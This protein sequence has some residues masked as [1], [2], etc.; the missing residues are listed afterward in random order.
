[1]ALSFTA[2][3]QPIVQ[4]S[5]LLSSNAQKGSASLAA[6][7]SVS[8][9]LRQ[10]SFLPAHPFSKPLASGSHLASSGKVAI[11]SPRAKVSVGDAAPSFTLKD[12][13]GR[14]FSLSKFKG[15]NVVLYFYP[16]DDTPGCTKEACAFRDSYTVFR[17]LGAEV[18]GISADSPESH[19]LI[20]NNQFQPEKHVEKALEI[21]QA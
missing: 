14:P 10:S 7:S 18:I 1:M 11:V 13:R 16:A 3:T 20:F 6:S 17:K 15:K 4:N 21:L 5:S 9:N 19:Q 8:F 12:Q 2:P